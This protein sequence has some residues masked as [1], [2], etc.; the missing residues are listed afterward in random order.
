[1]IR[2]VPDMQH[3]SHGFF[4][5]LTVTEKITEGGIQ[6]PVQRLSPTVNPAE[7]TRQENK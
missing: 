3:S 1:M 6:V 5:K 4:F 2:S 7:F